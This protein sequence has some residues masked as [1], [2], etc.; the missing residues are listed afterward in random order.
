MT[1]VELYLLTR[2]YKITRNHHEMFLS[3]VGD[4]LK[5]KQ[6]LSMDDGKIRTIGSQRTSNYVLK[7]I[8]DYLN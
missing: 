6:I 1:D 3:G 8:K 2:S 4:V 7:C 5:T